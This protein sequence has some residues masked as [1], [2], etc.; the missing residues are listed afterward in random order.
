VASVMFDIS[1]EP[2]GPDSNGHHLRKDVTPDT[3]AVLARHVR[4]GQTNHPETYLRLHARFLFTE[5]PP[6]KKPWRG[7]I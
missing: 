3:G 6:I 1:D 2:I 7:C 4:G 5:G